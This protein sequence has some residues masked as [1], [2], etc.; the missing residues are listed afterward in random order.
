MIKVCKRVFLLLLGYFIFFT[1][2]D[3][4]ALSDVSIGVSEVTPGVKICTKSSIFS[5]KAFLYGWNSNSSISA[6][7]GEEMTLNE[8]GYYCYTVKEN[9][10]FSNVVFN[11]NFN[12]QTI[13]LSTIKD[14]GNLVNNYLYI[15]N[16]MY[17][18][19]YIGEWYIYDKS[20]L[21]TLLSSASS[22]IDNRLKYTKSTYNT[23]KNEYDISTGIINYENPYD[24]SDSPLIVNRDDSSG[25]SVY[26]SPYI[27]AYNRLSNAI[28]GL[29]KR[30]PI[31]VN[32]DII[33]GVVEAKYVDNAD[34]ENYVI[35]IDA[36]PISGYKLNTIKASVITG[37]NDSEPVLG[38]ELTVSKVGDKYQAIYS[39]DISNNYKGI[40]IDAS[41][42]KKVYKISFTVDKNGKVVYVKDGNEFDI[43]DV[44]EVEHGDDFL[45]RIIANDGYI[46][47][48]A[49]VNGSAAEITDNYLNI[50]NVGTDQ[51]VE[52]SFTLKTYNVSIDDVNY[53]FPHG[54]TYDEIV[55]KVNPSKDG[56]VFI[57]FVDKDKNRVSKDYVVKANDSLYTLFNDK[58]EIINPET[59]MNVLKVIVLF[60]FIIIL[61][62]I[63]GKNIE[64]RKKKKI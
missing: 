51:H 28:G 61:L 15:F 8:D 59:G 20:G 63:N 13:D 34:N 45:A 54:T 36:Q 42:S 46:L 24:S 62:Y 4:L 1:G 53:V 2:M 17:D 30:L 44:V 32:D 50:K 22:K 26:S 27:D 10:T 57:G 49:T 12:A 55:S 38:D 31:V 3:V 37:Y 41:F 33:T 48:S 40:Y 18:G 23:L 21:L 25:T 29:S 19:K 47:K 5:D 52:L 11:N 43:N 6:W 56:Y 35:S 7:P 64:K 14:N 39:E 16:D 58:N 9:N 60:T